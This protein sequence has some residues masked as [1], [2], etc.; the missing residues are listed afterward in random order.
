MAIAGLCLEGFR[1]R[2]MDYPTPRLMGFHF[3]KHLSPLVLASE[4]EMSSDSAVAT[5]VFRWVSWVPCHACSTWVARGGS[6]WMR[7]CWEPFRGTSGCSCHPQQPCAETVI[8]GQLWS[9]RAVL[10]TF[11]QV[12]CGGVPQASTTL[13]QTD[14]LPT[15]C[16]LLTLPSPQPCEVGT[17]LYTRKLRHKD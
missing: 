11:L 17:V 16:T 4:H 12:G 5:A 15:P 9:P 8:E 7:G 3:A 2:R 14:M 6:H 13:S 10:E 1:H